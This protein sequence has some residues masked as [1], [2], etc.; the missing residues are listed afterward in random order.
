MPEEKQIQL[1]A[2][3][4]D[5]I[6][7]RRRQIDDE[8]FSVQRDDGYVKTEL[9]QAA[10]AY[11]SCAGQP[12]VLTTQWPWGVSANT[13]KPS[14]DRRRDLVKAGALI[15][16][17]IERVDRIGLIQHAV[18][19]RDKDGWWSHPDY[20][21]EFDDEITPEQFA[22]WCKRQ[23]VETKVSY[24][25]TDVDDEVFQAYMN[26]GQCNCSAWDITHPAEQGWFILSIHDAE[27]GPVCVW[28]RRVAA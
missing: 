11:A 3:A 15:L 10:A 9:A 17:E 13:W 8:G 14:S 4:R 12:N 25:E 6:A 24:M 18:V 16:A 27:D 7:E 2:A 26:D 28:G 5:V 1:N 22:E 20:L 21:S 19:R 23:Q